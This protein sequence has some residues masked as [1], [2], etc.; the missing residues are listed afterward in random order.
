MPST[1]GA[2]RAD[3]A[4]ALDLRS[5]LPI[6]WSVSCK[7]AMAFTIDHD[8]ARAVLLHPRGGHASSQCSG[9]HEI[10]TAMNKYN[11]PS[12]NST[13]VNIGNAS[14]QDDIS[15]VLVPVFEDAGPVS[16]AH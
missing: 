2:C 14:N 12:F 8:K 6:V 10:A 1:A 16:D 3:R 7:R 15:P 9:N 13:S 5:S 11:N 4:L